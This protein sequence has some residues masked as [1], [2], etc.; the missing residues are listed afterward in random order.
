MKPLSEK[1]A[2][3]NNLFDQYIKLFDN[4]HH[5]FCGGYWTIRYD[6]D[7]YMGGRGSWEV[8]H[9]CCIDSFKSCGNNLESLLDSLEKEVKGWIKDYKTL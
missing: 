4:D 7:A 5:K 3:I 2:K 8:T 6:Y 9:I 1:I